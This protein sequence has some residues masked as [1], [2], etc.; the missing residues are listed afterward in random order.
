[1][2]VGQ[3][4][5][6]VT[7]LSSSVPGLPPSQALSASTGAIGPPSAVIPPTLTPHSGTAPSNVVGGPPSGPHLGLTPFGTPPAVAGSMS[8]FM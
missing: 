7:S 1:M 5:N 6:L 2:S 8:S 4:M 3:P